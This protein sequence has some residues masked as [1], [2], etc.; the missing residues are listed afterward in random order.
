MIKTLIIILIIL[1]FLIIGFVGLWAFCIISA[2]NS[3]LEEQLEL[4]RKLRN[5]K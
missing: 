5:R 2:R 3:E 4:E 1:V